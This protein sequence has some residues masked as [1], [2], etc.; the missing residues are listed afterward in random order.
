MENKKDTVSN[1]INLPEE[2]H[3]KLKIEAISKNKSLHDVM[4]EC[5][6]KGIVLISNPVQTNSKILSQA[7]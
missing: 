3:K 6:E 1:I 7:Q 4:V 2:L 5:V